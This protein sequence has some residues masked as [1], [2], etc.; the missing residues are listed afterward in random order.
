MSKIKLSVYLILS[1]FPFVDFHFKCFYCSKII[2]MF[3]NGIYL[4]VEKSQ[5]SN[6]SWSILPVP[7][8]SNHNLLI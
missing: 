3:F 1:E 5:R 4:S 6:I 8:S 2:P 7:V